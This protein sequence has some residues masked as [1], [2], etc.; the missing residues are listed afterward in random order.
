MQVQEELQ[1]FIKE[2]CFNKENWNDSATF[3]LNKGDMVMF[4]PFLWHSISKN[5]VKVFYLEANVNTI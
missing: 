5:I 2:N 1:G 3:E 4:K